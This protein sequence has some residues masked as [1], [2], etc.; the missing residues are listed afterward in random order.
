MSKYIPKSRNNPNKGEVQF[1]P[2]RFGLY[3]GLLVSE[4]QMIQ[5]Q[6]AGALTKEGVQECIDRWE[7]EKD[8][9]AARNEAARKS[10]EYH[11]NVLGELLA[12]N[13]DVSDRSDSKPE[14]KKV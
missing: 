7:Q 2:R 10:T 13:K 5:L 4:S 11:M 9:I 1:A 8:R 14:D 3:Q 6:F 12:E